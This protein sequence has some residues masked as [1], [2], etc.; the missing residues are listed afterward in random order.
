MLASAC[1]RS[2]G[3]NV[4][5]Q[6]ANGAL[7]VLEP[8]NDALEVLGP[9]GPPQVCSP[10]YGAAQISLREREPPTPVLLF[11]PAPEDSEDGLNV[12]RR[13]YLAH[14]ADEGLA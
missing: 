3:T 7:G 11:I 9:G 8:G 10:E 12:G 14:E 5:V 1:Q 4:P 2:L 13:P 6:D